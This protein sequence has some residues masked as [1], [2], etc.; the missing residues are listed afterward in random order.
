MVSTRTRGGSGSA[1]T[2]RVA[3]IPSTSRHPDVHQ[4]DV[5]RQ[6]A[7][8]ARR[9]PG[10]HRPRPTISRSGSADEDHPQPGADQRLVVGQEHPD[11]RLGH[12]LLQRVGQPGPDPVAAGLDRPGVDVAADDRH[13]L[14]DADQAVAGPVRRD[15]RGAAV[16]DHGD[17]QRVVGVLQADPGGRRP[18]RA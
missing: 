15:R 6:L 5:G 8:T 11:H 4:D 12:E 7:R 9:R 14:A 18:R 1:V 17:G 13:P 3:S 16:V 10:R 2:A